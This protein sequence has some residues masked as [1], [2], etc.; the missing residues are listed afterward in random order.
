MFTIRTPRP[1]D[2]PSLKTLL[3]NSGLPADDLDQAK[4]NHFIVLAQ[5]QR[6]VGSV[7][8][9]PF[10]QDGLLRSLAVDTNHREEGFGSRLL[11]AIETHAAEIGIQHLYLLT[12][13][14]TSFFEHHGYQR[15][16]RAAAPAPIQATA[17]FTAMCPDSAACLFKSLDQ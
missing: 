17:E 4:L 1:E 10:G 16:E 2:L 13:S 9:E 6:I 11:E 5:G 7:G 3:T 14:A 15:M 8:L 12:T